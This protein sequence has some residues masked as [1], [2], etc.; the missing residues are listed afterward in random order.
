[1][2]SLFLLSPHH[3]PFSFSFS[4]SSLLFAFLPSPSLL[5][6]LRM[7]EIQREYESLVLSCLPSFITAAAIVFSGAAVF[8]LIFLVI[9]P[10]HLQQVLIFIVS[11]LYLSFSFLFCCTLQTI[12]QS[13]F[14]SYY[15]F[16]D[17]ANKN[18]SLMNVALVPSFF[19]SLP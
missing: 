3:S 6:L 4:S 1:M 9:Q 10:F 5:T 12:L 14:H 7:R 13:H 11:S 2:S 8:L 17:P 19:S 15:P 18:S 16:R